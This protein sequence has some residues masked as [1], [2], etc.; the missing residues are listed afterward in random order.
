MNDPTKARIWEQIKNKGKQVKGKNVV[1]NR[2]EKSGRAR[3]F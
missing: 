3:F 1:K 2:A